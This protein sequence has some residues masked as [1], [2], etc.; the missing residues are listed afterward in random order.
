MQYVQKVRK[1]MFIDIDICAIK[2][3]IMHELIEEHIKLI[4]IKVP[5]N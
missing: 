2:H 5:N 3:Q 1:R 4:L